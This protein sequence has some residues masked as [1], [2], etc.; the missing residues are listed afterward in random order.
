M[1]S[2]RSSTAVSANGYNAICVLMDICLKALTSLNAD[3]GADIVI[4]WIFAVMRKGEPMVADNQIQVW[5]DGSKESGFVLKV[6]SRY[7]DDPRFTLEQE[8]AIHEI[9][10]SFLLVNR[11]TERR[12]RYAEKKK[13]E[14]RIDD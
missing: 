14:R 3:I 13:A 11:Q 4:R 6:Q 8:S 1:N 9:V 2:Q 5:Q 12:K 7:L 10:R